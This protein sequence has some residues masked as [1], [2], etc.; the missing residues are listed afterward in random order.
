MNQLEIQQKLEEVL[1]KF[2]KHAH[3]WFPD[4]A[5]QKDGVKALIVQRFGVEMT[6]W[7]REMD[8]GSING[9]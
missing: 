8:L 7:I 2:L 9:R 1:D 3:G 5:D 6:R 4:S